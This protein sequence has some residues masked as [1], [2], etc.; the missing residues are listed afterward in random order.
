MQDRAAGWALTPAALSGGHGGSASW[1][2]R[3]VAVADC[4]DAVSAAVAWWTARTIQNRPH[5]TMLVQ[6]RRR[7]RSNVRS[8]DG[9]DEFVTRSVGGRYYIWC[10][11]NGCAV[12]E[13]LMV[14]ADPAKQPLLFHCTRYR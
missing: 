5:G 8:L 7:F 3:Q 13:A 4:R 10:T 6:R 2:M 1:T 14:A 12:R 9:H 11:V